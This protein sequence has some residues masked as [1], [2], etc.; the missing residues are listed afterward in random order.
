[1]KI[2]IFFFTV[3]LFIF[4]GAALAVEPTDVVVDLAAPQD[5]GDLV[6]LYRNANGNPILSE[7][8]GGTGLCEQPIAFPSD[9]C[10][11]ECVEG[12]PCL[13][14]V[15]PTTC[16]IEVGYETCTQEVDFGRI[17]SARSPPSVFAAQLEDV[18]VK[19]ATADCITLDPSGRLVASTVEGDV[20]STA[21]IDSPIQNLAIYKQIMLTGFLGEESAPIMLPATPLDTA[22]RG[23]GVASDKIGEVNVDLLVYLNQV[24]G[25][26]DLESTYLGAPICQ[27]NREEVQGVVQEVEK[28]FLNYGAYGYDRTSNFG[29]L[30][31]PA[32][33][34]ENNPEDGTFEYLAL[35]PGSEDDPRFYIVQGPI[36]GAVF[37]DDPGHNNVYMN[38]NLGGVMNGNIS[39]FAQA[40]DDTRAVINFMHS[41]PIPFGYATAVVCQASGDIGY[42]VLISDVS[43][44]QVPVSMVDG[45]EEG[46]EFIVTV[47]NAGPDPATGT[48][49]V[50]A[51]EAN[52]DSIPTF[53]RV[54]SF[55]DLAPNG[56]PFSVTENFVVDLGYTTTITWT[57]TVVAEFDVNPGNNSVTE[58]TSVTTTNMPVLAITSPNGGETLIGTKTASINWTAPPTAESF[59]LRYSMNGG[60]N[61]NDIDLNV[62]NTNTYLWNV[63]DVPFQR[64]S[65]LVKVQAYNGSGIFLGSDVSDDFFTIAV[66]PTEIISPNGGETWT[67]GTTQTIIWGAP[68]KAV[69]FALRYS[70]NNGVNWFVI[71]DTIGNVRSYQWTLPTY[72]NPKTALVRIQAFNQ[73]G[74]K[75]G[76]DDSDASFV[77]QP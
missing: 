46:R 63:P 76:E 48:V 9:T 74:W 4:S 51:K 55:T 8:V 42:D 40:A 50:T 75:I 14:P 23:V 35:V 43:G 56:A 6:I 77:I 71:D 13:V 31:Y 3:I 68:V 59:K 64:T 66:A 38:G 62:G 5:Y 2:R 58:T 20:V 36:M 65:C 21:A 34:P 33:I 60:L 41:N 72:A 52:G 67:G 18:I 61:W 12:E 39:S 15:N 32:Y 16:A 22:A 11:V 25:L 49:T 29:S 28:C 37:L 70:P 45:M 44:L 26:S 1:M 69:A 10:S 54:F 53:P 19:L 27:L 73:S 57:A 30:P 47:G 24:L 7:A 17:D